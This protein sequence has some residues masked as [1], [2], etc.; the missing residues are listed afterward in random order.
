MKIL[1]TS[2]HPVLPTQYKRCDFWSEACR[3]EKAMKELGY[4]V[5]VKEYMK[6][7]GEGEKKGDWED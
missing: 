1:V 6:V 5:L 4:K 3:E 7:V 2:T